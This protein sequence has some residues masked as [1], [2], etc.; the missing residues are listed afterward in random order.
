MQPL[1]LTK[2]YLVLI[3]GKKKWPIKTKSL[4]ISTKHDSSLNPPVY[5]DRKKIEEVKSFTY[6]G[7]SFSHNLKWNN[8]IEEVS[9]K[10]RKRLSAMSPLKK[11]LDRK[12]LHSIY[13]A[14]V[15]PVMEYGIVVWGGSYDND[16]YKLEQINI[17]AMR[18]ISGATANSNIHN[19]YIETALISIRERAENAYYVVQ[20]HYFNV[21]IISDRSLTSF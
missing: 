14:F 9:I 20:S 4:I 15:R 7:L 21:S 17:A 5:L 19:L 10:A 13:M 12:A 3:C 16:I 6:L 2:I 1:K 18:L 8:H 11:M